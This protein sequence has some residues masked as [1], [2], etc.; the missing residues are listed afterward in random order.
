MQKQPTVIDQPN[1]L[2]SAL[3]DV[4]QLAAGEA[5]RQGRLLSFKIVHALPTWI[6]TDLESFKHGLVDAISRQLT[7]SKSKETYVLCTCSRPSESHDVDLEFTATDL[8]GFKLS[9]DAKPF[10][11]YT[12]Q[13]YAERET[14]KHLLPPENDENHL[15]VVDELLTGFCILVVDDSQEC[16]DYETRLI[17]KFGGKFE[18]ARNGTEAVELALEKHFDLVLMDIKMPDV[19][20]NDAMQSLIKKSYR[21]PVVALSAF[22]SVAERKESLKLGFSDYLSK[23]IVPDQLLRTIARLTH[24]SLPVLKAVLT[25]STPGYN[26]I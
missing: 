24:R 12:L 9:S 4:V 3:Y 19:S 17:E 20:G 8:P 18:V 10:F 2:P 25:E 5:F 6:E 14:F 22:I 7:K 13:S 21:S 16:L 23:P 1:S 15:R 26:R 11:S